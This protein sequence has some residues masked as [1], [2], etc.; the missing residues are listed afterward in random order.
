MC[1]RRVKR[2]LQPSCVHSNLLGPCFFAVV[3]LPPV[4]PELE[5]A[6]TWMA[7]AA[8][9]ACPSNPSMPG[10]VFRLYS[11]SGRRGFR[12]NLG[13]RVRP[14]SPTWPK[15]G[16]ELDLIAG[17]KA[18]GLML[19]FGRVCHPYQLPTRALRS[20]DMHPAFLPHFC[21]GHACM[22]AAITLTTPE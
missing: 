8:D 13:W 7:P 12:G 21:T 20:P 1:S 10:T 9:V 16:E 15:M 14:W 18:F 22:P 6:A 5:P 4:A 2:L 19:V 17:A 3:V 11:E